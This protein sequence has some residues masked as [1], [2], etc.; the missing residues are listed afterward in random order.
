MF[1]PHFNGWT[2]D[3]AT[4]A[5]DDIEWAGKGQRRGSHANP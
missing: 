5:A 3:Q 1:Q 2:L 4:G